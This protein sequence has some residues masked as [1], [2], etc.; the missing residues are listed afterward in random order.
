[1]RAPYDALRVAPELNG[2][3]LKALE[4]TRWTFQQGDAV[5]SRAVAQQRTRPAEG[6]FEYLRRPYPELGVQG[7]DDPACPDEAVEIHRPDMDRRARLR[8]FRDLAIADVDDDMTHWSVEE[9]Q[10]ARL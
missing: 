7:S 3:E 10:V 8:C 1:M 5:A 2:L 9:E 4:L 6:K